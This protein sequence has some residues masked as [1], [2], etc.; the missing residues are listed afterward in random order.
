MRIERPREIERFGAVRFGGL[1]KVFELDSGLRRDK[2]PEKGSTI[3]QF[4]YEELYDIEK[5]MAVVVP[6]Y[7]EQLKLIEGVLSGIPH[8]CLII[9]VSNSPTVPVDRFAMEQDAL[10]RFCHSIRRIQFSPRPLRTPDTPA[11]WTRR[12]RYATARRRGC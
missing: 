1:Q 4:P 3:I 9:I 6:I 5:E 11:S 8:Q 10:R 2:L 7:Q 12:A